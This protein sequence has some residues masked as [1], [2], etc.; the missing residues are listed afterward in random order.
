MN[1][2]LKTMALGLLLAAALTVAIPTQAHAQVIIVQSPPVYSPPPIVTYRTYSPP[3]YVVP[4]IAYSAPVYTAPRVSYYPAPVVSY[5]APVVSYS[6]PITT[7]S[8]YAA[9]V[10]T[11]PAPGVYTTYSYWNG[12]GIFRPRYVNQTY[13]T[14]VHP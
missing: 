12:L 14:P 11:S 9:P 3:T 7:Y 6:A 5:S 8:P 2:M 1:R 13:Y 4:S 10:V